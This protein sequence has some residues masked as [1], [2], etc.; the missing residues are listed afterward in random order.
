MMILTQL[1]ELGN[2]TPNHIFPDV[3][4]HPEALGNP[5]TRGSCA[6]PGKLLEPES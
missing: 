5:K 1:L 4:K 6:C 2:M 3:Q